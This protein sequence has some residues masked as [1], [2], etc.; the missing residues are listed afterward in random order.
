MIR[1]LIKRRNL[2]TET[3]TQKEC[4]VKTA[5]TL[6]QAK[7]PP[8]A[9]SG[10]EQTNPSLASSGGAGTCPCLELALPAYKAETITFLLLAS[11]SVVLCY[12]SPS[13]LTKCLTVLPPE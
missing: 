3:G 1:V 10:L 13:T 9:R 4:Y 5:A 8:E 6:A 11:Q 7:E 2:D 12:V